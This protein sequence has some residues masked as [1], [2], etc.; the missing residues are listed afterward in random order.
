M[1]LRL[2]PRARGPFP[3]WAASLAALACAALWL[4]T[5]WTWPTL[6][7]PW[8]AASL[9]HGMLDIEQLEPNGNPPESRLAVSSVSLDDL[10]GYDFRYRFG[11][12]EWR[13]HAGSVVLLSGTGRRWYLDLPLWIPFLLFSTLAAIAWRA[14][15]KPRDAAQIACA[16]CNYNLAGLPAGSLCPECGK[17]SLIRPPASRPPLPAPAPRGL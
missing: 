7:T 13:P 12:M 8:F 6:S 3:R 14:H 4:L 1:M 16:H 5:L 9:C 2:L 10:P 17:H 11:F 15:T